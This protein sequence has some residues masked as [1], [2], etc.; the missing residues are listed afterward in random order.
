[1]HVH[2]KL[3]KGVKLAVAKII[4]YKLCLLMHL[5][6][7]LFQIYPEQHSRLPSLL[8]LAH[9]KVKQNVE[10]HFYLFICIISSNITCTNPVTLQCC[11]FYF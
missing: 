5:F 4:L 10:I 8:L 6:S 9:V 3:K 7:I 2:Y 1:M 11:C